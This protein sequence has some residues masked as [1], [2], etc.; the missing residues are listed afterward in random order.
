MKLK[1]CG[2]KYNLADVSGLIP[3]YIGLIFW[4]GSKRFISEPLDT[5]CNSKPEKV[6][7]FVDASEDFILQKIATY[8]L[9]LLQLHGSETPEFCSEIKNSALSALGKEIKIIKAFSVGNSFNFE[10]LECYQ[11]SCEFFLFDSR[12]PLPGGNGTSF[13]WNVLHDYTLST[14]YF[15]SGGISLADELKLIE[16]LNHPASEWCHALDVNSGFE[17]RPGLKDI[18]KLKVFMNSR[19]WL[20]GSN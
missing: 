11:D 15:L 6:G 19:L 20:T 9:D 7:V 16:F 5:S 10:S 1:I 13:N 4:E 8:N 14:P 3:D 18:E 17:I 12:G 2:L